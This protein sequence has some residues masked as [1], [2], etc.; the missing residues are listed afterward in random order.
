MPSPSR[1]QT[2]PRNL[3][4]IAVCTA[5]L[6]PALAL[7]V[8][9]QV[10][11]QGEVE[12][13][14]GGPVTDTLEFTF[15]LFDAAEDGNEVWSEVR[16]INVV[17]GDYSVLLG[18]EIAID[19]VLFSEPALY[20]QITIEGGEPLLPRQPVASA[21]YAIVAN[22]A[23]NLD[24]GTVNASSLS[25]NGT[26]VVDASG[27]W[28]GGAGSI[29]WSALDGV[30]AD[31]DTLAGLGL[32]CADG[33]VAKWDGL[34]QWTCATDLV[35]TSAQ[36]LGFVGGA[37]L[38]LGAGSSMSGVTLATLDDLD[39]S[40]LTGVP[41]GF[42]DD[43]D[44]DT[45]AALGLLCAEADRAAWDEAFGEW[46]CASEEVA[47][48]RLDTGGA[49]EGQVLTFDGTNVAW[50]DP[51]TTTNPP[52]TL[53]VLDETLRAALVNCGATSIALRTWMRPTQV[54]AGSEH[55]CGIDSSGSVQCWGFNNFG[56]SMPPAGA[57]TQVSGGGTHTCAI[58]SSSGSVQCWGQ[59]GNGQSTPPAGAFTQVSAGNSHTCG[60]DSSGA[61][62]CW[63]YD[64]SGQS[65]P[66]AGTFTQVSAGYIHTCAVMQTLETVICWGQD[67]YGQ[68]TPP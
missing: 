48:D 56:Q 18:S 64:G 38:D 44:D 58:D 11:H 55:T 43:V 39:W 63:G 37:T 24:G 53:S 67:A 59:N 2:V 62:Q 23:I 68:A 7:G 34:S 17:D 15:A 32:S 36:V 22:T 3:P 47:L 21:P 12:D 20:L 13:A 1:R 30:P 41:V 49:A 61:V 9:L 60:I 16:D 28:V 42:A 66:P 14:D 31:Q 8:P 10:A 4:I 50:E 26:A 25:V 33:S 46:V 27:D 54:S 6:A 57:F 5:L 51:A 29:D 19:S 45:L 52:C 35:L 65:T 40:M